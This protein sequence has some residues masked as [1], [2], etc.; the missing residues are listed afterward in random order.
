MNR[1]AISLLSGGLDSALSTKLIIDQGIEVVGLHFTSHFASKRD[2]ERGL[3]AVK[4]ADELGIRLVVKDKGPEYLEVIRKPRY[5]YGKNMNPCIDCRIFMLQKSEIV[6]TEENAGFLITGEVIG[7]RPMSQ[8]RHAIELIE[9]KS[10]LTGLI[11]RPL[12]AN[13]FPPTIPEQKGIIDRENL[14]NL[15][16]RSRET[17]YN[18]VEL[19]NMKEF[20]RP[21][22]GCLL[23]DPIF[24]CKLKDFMSENPEFTSRDIEL[25][26]MGRYFRLDKDTVL[27]I[28]RNQ[29]ENGRLESF[30]EIPY[31]L[32][33]PCNF[34]GPKGVLRGTV[35]N[36]TLKIAAHI[37]V[38]YSKQGLSTIIIESSNGVSET[39]AFAKEEI[40]I[41]PFKVKGTG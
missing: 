3:Q 39:H 12:S 35:S 9:K 24:S 2:K 16:G 19:H 17:Q 18:L 32:L 33:S 38:F 29:E 27:F 11:L 23:T 34:K 7:Q 13:L 31:K 15:S 41:E 28:G 30:R 14:L 6:M 20:A 5:G 1:K 37:M 36:S 40:A 25:L 22:G 8:T 10:G 21:G 4:T 26:T